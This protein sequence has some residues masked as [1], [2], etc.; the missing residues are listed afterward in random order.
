MAL[1]ALVELVRGSLENVARV[2]IPKGLTG[3]VA[4]GDVDLVRR[5]VESLGPAERA[6][7]LALLEATL[8]LARAKGALTPAAD[9][10]LRRVLGTRYGAGAS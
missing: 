2:G 6:L 1:E 10:A 5:H 9:A 4:R 8:P 3:P 7:Y